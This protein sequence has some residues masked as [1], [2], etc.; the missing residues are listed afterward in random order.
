VASLD[1]VP[2]RARRARRGR[3]PA[4]WRALYGK[5]RYDEAL[6]A[7]RQQGFAELLTRLGAA[8]LRELADAARFAGEAREAEQA[9]LALRERFPRDRRARVAAFLLGRVAMDLGRRPAQ[10]VTWFQ[11]YLHEDPSGPLAEEAL[12][13]LVDALARA[14]QRARARDAAGQYLGRYPDGLFS[15]LARSVLKD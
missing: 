6:A 5:G 2:R 11:T 1:P 10:A 9:L 15:E 3:A 7:A 12:G 14:G 8:E 13:R 4:G